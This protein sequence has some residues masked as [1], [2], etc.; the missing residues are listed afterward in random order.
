[1]RPAG[2]FFNSGLHSTAGFLATAAIS[3]GLW[4]MSFGMKSKKQ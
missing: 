3:W 2:A 1:M 4:Y